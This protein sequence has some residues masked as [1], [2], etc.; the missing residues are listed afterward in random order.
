[1]RK[2]SSQEAK[3]IGWQTF[4]VFLKT[5]DMLP[6]QNMEASVGGCVAMFQV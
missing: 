6:V 4:F 2:I 5:E 1:M 3:L